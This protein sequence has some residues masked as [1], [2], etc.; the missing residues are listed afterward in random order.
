MGWLYGWYAEDPNFKRGVRVLIEG[1]YEPP[2]MS[3]FN[4]VKLMKDKFKK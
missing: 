2:Q 4:G 3:S 1:I